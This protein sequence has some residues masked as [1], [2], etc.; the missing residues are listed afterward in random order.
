VPDAVVELGPA[1]S[2]F[3]LVENDYY[4]D[5]AKVRNFVT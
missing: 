3:G 4:G 2:D 1:P 5:A